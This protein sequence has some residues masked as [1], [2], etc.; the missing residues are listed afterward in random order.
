MAAE[1]FIARKLRFKGKVAMLCIALSFFVM[2]IAVSVASGYRK[3]ILDG[4]R[5]LNGDIRLSSRSGNYLDELTPVSSQISVIEKIDSLPEVVSVTP[6]A[7]RAGIVTGS[8]LIHGVM[9]K[10]VP[11]FQAV[12]ASGEPVR[13]G[14][15]IP[16]R[17]AR[18]LSLRE[19]DRLTAYFVGEKTK[20]RKFTVSGIYD[21]VIDSDDKQLVY[22]DLA[23]IQRLNGWSG[24]EVSAFEV[25]VRDDCLDSGALAELTSRIGTMAYALSSDDDDALV[26]VS[27]ESAYPQMFDW[28]RLI[29][30]NVYVILILMT[31]V[32][33][34]NMISGL[35]ILL[36][37]NISTIGLLKSL[38]M[39]DR[40][41]AGVFLCSSSVLV[42]KGMAIGNA[43]A[44]LLCA[45]QRHFHILKLD[46]QNYFVS[47]VPVSPDIPL[48]LAAD[49]ASF[50]LIMLMLL[51]PCLFI[52]RVDPART[53][54]AD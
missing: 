10:G 14:I 54:R 21:A 52:S 43:L 17:L 48:I 4:L 37:E 38:G 13:D 42:L 46:P 49:A 36:F 32:A 20:V 47:F 33:G 25:K 29:D 18:M 12:N 9:F 35:L 34:F 31:V 51:A 15:S 6:V 22:V 3:A 28:L 16:R 26:A 44:I 23:V 1:T 30:F 53:V 45:L 2:I 41:I 8:G 40:S 19:G 5:E 39:N 50:V 24:S 11:D 27:S 7:Y